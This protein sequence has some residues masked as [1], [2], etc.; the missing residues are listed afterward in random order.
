M[1]PP[2][3][4]LGGEATW[5]YVPLPECPDFTATWKL[6]EA[7]KPRVTDLKAVFKFS[8]EDV[9]DGKDEVKVYPEL[10]KR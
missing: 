3:I 8:D 2:E 5:R 9:L 4:A 7:D 10:T 1:T 6:P